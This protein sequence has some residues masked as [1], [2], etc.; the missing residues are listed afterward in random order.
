M[1]FARGSAYPH[2]LPAVVD[3]VGLCSSTELPGSIAQVLHSAAAL[4]EAKPWFELTPTTCPVLLTPGRLTR[5]PAQQRSQIG[6][7]VVTLGVR[8]VPQDDQQRQSGQKQLPTLLSFFR[9]A[10]QF[11]R[12]TAGTFAGTGPEGALHKWCLSP[13]LPQFRR[14]ATASRPMAPMASRIRHDGSGT[15]AMPVPASLAVV[16]QH[17]RQVVDVHLA[18]PGKIAL[19]PSHTRVLPKFAS[20]MVRSLMSTLPSPLASPGSSATPVTA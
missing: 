18:V 10:N 11:R 2:H 12:N 5:W 14:R 1:E 3:A 8:P 9:L 19:G 17:D 4:P 7:G 6:H 20:T 13:S 15:A 16:R